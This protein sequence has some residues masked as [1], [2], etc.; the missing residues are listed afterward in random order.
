MTTSYIE[1][2]IDDS[3]LVNCEIGRCSWSTVIPVLAVSVYNSSGTIKLFNEDGIVIETKTDNDLSS[4]I[5]VKSS[6]HVADFKWHPKLPVLAVSWENGDLGCFLVQKL[7]CKWVYSTSNEDILLNSKWIAHMAWID[8]GDK[9]ITVNSSGLLVIW[10]YNS[11]TNM[12]TSTYSY[13]MV[14]RPTD[15]TVVTSKTRYP[16]VLIACS[17]GIIHQYTVST[18]SISDVIQLDNGV[19]RIIYNAHKNRIILVTDNLFLCQYSVSSSSFEEFSEISKIKLSGHVKGTNSDMV[20]VNMVDESIGLIA[21]CTSGERVIRLW[22]L[23]TGHNAALMVVDSVDSN[24]AGLSCLD[25]SETLLVAGTTNG[26][27]IIWKRISGLD[28]NKISQVSVKGNVKTLSISNTNQIACTTNSNQIYLIEE[29]SIITSYHSD[30]GLV[31]TGAKALKLF[32]IP[33]N[34][35]Y[36]LN[37]QSPIRSALVSTDASYVAIKS[38]GVKD[39]MIYR[40]SHD[41]DLIREAAAPIASHWFALH[42]D[43]IWTLNQ[44]NDEACTLQCYKISDLP[45]NNP[46]NFELDTSLFKEKPSVHTFDLN[47]DYLLILLK[48]ESLYV[49]YIYRIDGANANIVS[50]PKILDLPSENRKDSVD[51]DNLTT[52][53]R[54]FSSPPP[55]SGSNSSSKTTIELKE[56]K[57]NNQGSHFAFILYGIDI[58]V[59]HASNNL[60]AKVNHELSESSRLIWSTNESRLFCTLSSGKLNI[61]LCSGDNEISVKLYSSKLVDPGCRLIG[62]K[63]PYVFLMDPRP[64]GSIVRE[65]LEEFEDLSG[66]TTRIMVDFLTST[67]ID[68]NS[69]IKKIGER[70]GNNNKI[71]TNLARIAVK[72]RDIKT[73]LYC[74][75]KM[76]NARVVQDVREKLSN[77]SEALALLAMNLELHREAEDF[78]KE[79][80]DSYALS[81]YYQNRNEWKRAIE[82]TDKLHFKTVCYNYAKNLELEEGNL[83]EA[84][85]YYEM[86]ATHIFEVP[87]ML[88]DIEGNTLLENY[89]IAHSIESSS[90]DNFTKQDRIQLCRWWGQYCESLGD[91]N[92]ALESY[93][94][95]GDYYNLV[96]LLCYSGQ[97]EKA[98]SLMADLNNTVG[99]K[100]NRSNILE[101]P[102]ESKSNKD[103]ALLHLGRHLEPTSPSESIGYYLSCGAINHAIRVCKSNNLI[104]EL[105]KIIVNYGNRKDALSFL[106]RLPNSTISTLK[107]THGTEEPLETNLLIQLYHK[108]D[109]VDGAIRLCLETGRWTDL[110]ELMTKE[111]EKLE[112]GLQVTC[113]VSEAT[114]VSAL[115]ALKNNSE[116]IDIVIDL[117]LLTKGD[118]SL[119]QN[120]ILD[121]NIEINEKLME[122]VDRVMAKEG[123]NR[124]IQVLAETALQQ[125]QYFV[126]ARLYNSIGDRVSSLKSLIRTGSTDKVVNYANIARDK[127]VY[128]IAANYLQTVNYSDDNLIATFYKKAG[129]KQELR[130]FMSRE[131]HSLDGETS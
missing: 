81:K 37:L 47:H 113:D 77:E 63:V 99:T 89:C 120:L 108:A 48:L 14:D 50:G 107:Q 57:L 98:K 79:S 34:K 5:P 53:N 17:S 90:S 93:E 86:S 115:E 129:A 72:C 110:R 84:I 20:A 9:L 91:S 96:R 69:I 15:L 62:F 31:Q 25:C 123:D 66:E 4:S 82:V 125:G 23:E 36:E 80:E 97:T 19:R 1:F 42:Y 10:D 95:A 106:E 75:A 40:T 118:K 41:P 6:A 128:R 131:G 111:M 119:I 78:L 27:I 11:T 87:R 94:K 2:N 38:T 126:A 67:N 105:V 65:V 24:W 29:Q 22:Q 59:V 122:K 51:S 32:W 13:Q 70:E 127:S 46:F 3:S 71:W 52:T 30:L 60:I 44:S 102:T 7:Q 85:K 45:S 43:T 83:E 12:L 109:L 92:Q 58:Y 130:R 76:K 55:M 112:A 61:F 8:P 16:R 39:L 26:L 56:V 35:C 68:L 121:Y 28:F 114:I 101:E 100:D 74:M 104:N 117:V 49:Y 88:F 73:G 124:L 103:A 54:S 116:I 21:I 64:N 18:G 33:E